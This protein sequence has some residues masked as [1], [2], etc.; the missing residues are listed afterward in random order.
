MRNKPK[1]QVA[2]DGTALLVLLTLLG[3]PL[4]PEW[5]HEWLGLGLLLM[6][7]LHNGLNARWYRNLVTG[8]YNLQRRLQLGVNGLSALLLLLALGSGLMLS[9]HLWP[10]FPLHQGTDLVRKI[11]MTAVHWLQLMIAV[12]LG[13]HW[14]LLGGFFCALMGIS[15]RNRLVRR[16]LASLWL[17]VAAYGATVFIRRDLPA[18]LLAQVDFSPLGAGFLTGKIDEHTQFDA[19]DFRSLV[20][21]FSTEARKANLVLVEMIK[22]IATGKGATPAQIALAWLLAQ[23]PWIVPIPGT[24]KLHRLE[25]NMGALEIELTERDLGQ[26]NT[27]LAKI[28]V[29]GDRLPEAV[30]KMTGL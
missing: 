15:G 7:L 16:S 17:A 9:R 14:K 24:T 12:H 3:Y 11:H 6:L 26:I 1:F 27:L 19:T 13:L 22:D 10:E 25:E 23:K 18:Y 29:Q 30:L 4:W 8:R 2:Q 20:P 21:R 5:L 28:E